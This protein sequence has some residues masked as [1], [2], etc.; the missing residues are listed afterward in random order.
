MYL[1][2]QSIVTH[3]LIEKSNITS[4]CICNN[5]HDH[6][7]FICFKISSYFHEKVTIQEEGLNFSLIT[8]LFQ[9]NILT[10]WIQ[11]LVFNTWIKQDKNSACLLIKKHTVNWNNKTRLK[12]RYFFLKSAECLKKNVL[13]QIRFQATIC[14][15]PIIPASFRGIKKRASFHAKK[16]KYIMAVKLTNLVK[17]LYLLSPSKMKPTLTNTCYPLQHKLS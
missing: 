2:K 13:G 10:Q 15:D 16:D 6:C 9:G 4:P 11:L 12:L 8:F 14:D 7:V 5:L 1:W 17:R 3:L